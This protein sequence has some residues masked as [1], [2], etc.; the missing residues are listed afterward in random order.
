MG[1]GVW[2]LPK[3]TSGKAPSSP[4]TVMGVVEPADQGGVDIAISRLTQILINN[5]WSWPVVQ[6]Q[7]ICVGYHWTSERE[8]VVATLR[9]YI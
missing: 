8:G 7:P 1:F 3:A 6:I 2:P 4:S 5:R 9:G